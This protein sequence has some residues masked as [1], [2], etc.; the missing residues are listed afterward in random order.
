MKKIISSESEIK[1]EKFRNLTKRFY[2]LQTKAECYFM[3]HRLEL[4]LRPFY[5]YFGL[6]SLS[7]LFYA[8][9]LKTIIHEYHLMFL[10]SVSTLILFVCIIGSFFVNKIQFRAGPV[11]FFFGSIFIIF[12]TLCTTKEVIHQMSFSIKDIQLLN[13]FGLYDYTSQ[14]IIASVFLIFTPV[15]I[16][17]FQ[18]FLFSWQLRR[19]KVAYDNFLKFYMPNLIKVVTD[20]TK[21]FDEFD[22]LGSPLSDSAS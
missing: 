17:A 8:G 14:Q 9:T 10:N 5:I 3:N 21:E 11:R 2:S 18:V 22:Q 16:E 7:L 19:L 20:K 6:M 1:E 12:V 15:I 4:F 13:Y